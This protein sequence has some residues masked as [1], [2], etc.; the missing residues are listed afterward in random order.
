M[1]KKKNSKKLILSTLNSFANISAPM[2][3]RANATAPTVNFIIK[4]D[5][6]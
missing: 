6:V 2:P 5:A 4:D 3:P 1:K